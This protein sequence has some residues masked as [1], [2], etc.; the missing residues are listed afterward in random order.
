MDAEDVALEHT[1]LSAP[2]TPDHVYCPHFISIM[3]RAVDT[4]YMLGHCINSG[5]ID[6][7]RGKF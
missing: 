2:A 4:W 5:L 6:S 7:H 3:S 1:Q